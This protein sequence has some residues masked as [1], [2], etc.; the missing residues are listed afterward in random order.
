MEQ[1]QTL[2]DKIIEAPTQVSVDKVFGAAQQV[3]GRTLIP[4]A[5]ISYGYGAGFGTAT[6]EE[7]PVAEGEQPKGSSGGGGGVGAK[8]RP[9]AYIEVGPEGT[10]VQPIMD[11]QKVAMAGILLSAWV[12]GWLGLV[13][14]TLFKD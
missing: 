9:L 8:A 7:E 11:E 10:S 14:K 6:D 1:M 2:I 3:E 4:V 13:L 5:E 12:I